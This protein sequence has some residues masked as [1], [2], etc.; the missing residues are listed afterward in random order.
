M[1]AS[2]LLNNILMVLTEQIARYWPQSS[3]CRQILTVFLFIFFFNV[4]LKRRKMSLTVMNDMCKLRLEPMPGV[5]LPLVFLVES[6]IYR[7]F[8]KK[9]FRITK[10]LDCTMQSIFW[11]CRISTLLLII[12][13]K[14]YFHSLERNICIFNSVL[15]KGYLDFR[16]L[17]LYLIFKAYSLEK[18]NNFFF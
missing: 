16:S 11:L 14:V 18:L 6:L 1:V 12:S 15:I 3:C 4:K 7:D 10:T 2:K 9:A 5:H 17:Q 13:F 8:S